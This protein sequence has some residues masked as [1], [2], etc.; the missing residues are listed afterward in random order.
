[1]SLGTRPGATG[2]GH[3]R[4]PTGGRASGIQGEGGG[5]GGMGMMALLGGQEG[6]ARPRKGRQQAVSPG[7]RRSG[8][9]ARGHR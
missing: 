8:R 2:R 7:Q 3:G 9:G 4:V 1:M 6:P 5:D